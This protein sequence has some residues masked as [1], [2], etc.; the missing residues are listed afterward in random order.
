VS[1]PVKTGLPVGLTL[2]GNYRLVWDAVD[3]TTGATVSGVVVSEMA[4]EAEL[5]EEPPLV[6][7]F[8]PTYLPITT[9]AA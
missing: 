3:P 6:E 5:V 9:E 8:V 7:T 4:L 1:L 2:P